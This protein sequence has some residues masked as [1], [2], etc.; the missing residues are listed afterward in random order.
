MRRRRRNHK[1]VVRK[2][3]QERQPELVW[4]RGWGWRRGSQETDMGGETSIKLS[5]DQ[6]NEVKERNEL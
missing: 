3:T 1:G 6:K 2:V 5:P 4:G